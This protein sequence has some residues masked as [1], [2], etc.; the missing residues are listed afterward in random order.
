MRRLSFKIGEAFPANS[1]VAHFVTVLAM[2][3]NDWRR[4]M[5]A[6]NPAPEDD[7]P[8]VRLLFVRQQLA[9][10]HGAPKS[11]I[12]CE[13]QPPVQEFIAGLSASARKQYA[14]VMAPP[15]RLRRL[16]KTQR[17]V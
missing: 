8:G 14:A 5:R 1:T 12:H 2:I 3:G 16:L 9:Y 13:G 11:L 10:L 15:D 17:N 4:T 7:G 6:M